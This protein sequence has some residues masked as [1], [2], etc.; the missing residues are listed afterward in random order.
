MPRRPY[1]PLHAIPSPDA[2]RAKLRETE[3]LTHRLR[4]LLEIA[5]R[6]QLPLT[7][8]ADLPHPTGGK[9]VPRG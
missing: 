5:E 4:V 1:D 3:A 6:L 7:T 8:G 2:I 9:A